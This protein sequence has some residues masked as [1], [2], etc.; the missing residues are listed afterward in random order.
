M[1]M[2]AADTYEI[3][4]EVGNLY[5]LYDDMIAR[6]I[7]KRID[8]QGKETY[9]YIKYDA[10]D[11]HTWTVYVTIKTDHLKKHITSLID[12]VTFEMLEDFK[13]PDPI[14]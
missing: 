8:S 2:L 1:D 12:H 13:F 3:E 5:N 7:N 10:Y 14:I 6:K 9:D 4:I 11:E